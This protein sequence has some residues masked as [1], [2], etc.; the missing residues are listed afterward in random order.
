MN[1]TSG[2][3]KEMNKGIAY[4]LCACFIWGFIFVIP[5]FM[6]GFSSLEVTL[7]RYLFYS[8]ISSLVF[9]K[10]F[11]QG[12]CH[13]HRPIW[14][15]AL[16]FSLVSTI[17]YYTFL[18]LAL[19]Y[20][21]PAICALILGISPI[22][23]A[24][25]G[26]SRQKEVAFK[27]LIAPSLL[28]LLGLII[29]NTPHLESSSSPSCY[30]LGLLFCILAL[31]SWSWYVVANSRFLKCHPEVRSSDW[32]TLIGVA[33]IFWVIAFAA[34]LIVFFE[35]QLHMEKYFIFNDELKRFLIGS[36][37]LGLVCSWVGAFLWNKASF[38]LPVSLAGQLTIFETI[39]AVLF[40]FLITQSLPSPI[41]GIGIAILF[42]AIAYAIKKFAIAKKAFSR[43]ISPH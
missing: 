11:L 27:S 43:Q 29:I 42:A 31:I 28:I 41:E 14:I 26:N 16:L 2:E 1:L 37:V 23:I 18:V 38:Y 21:S 22:T 9:I 10:S 40:V 32:S 15:K 35:D 19:R 34:I 17:G 6:T 30:I 24:L 12:T 3:K 7:G 36:A 5:Q 8:T 20:S 4:A 33:T 39:F 13:F 25:Y